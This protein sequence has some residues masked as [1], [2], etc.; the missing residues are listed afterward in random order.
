V[1]R[2]KNGTPSRHR[3]DCWLD[4][5]DTGRWACG[6]VA[7]TLS[8]TRQ[9]ADAAA[10][11][12]AKG[13]VERWNEQIAASRDM[14]WSPMIRAALHPGS[15]CSARAAGRAGRLIF[16]RSTDIPSP[17]SPLS[18]SGFGALGAQSRR[19][20]RGSSVCTLSRLRRRPRRPI[21]DL[22]AGPRQDSAAS[23]DVSASRSPIRRK[24][25]SWPIKTQYADQRAETINC[26]TPYPPRM[27]AA[28]LPAT[29]A[30]RKAAVMEY[31]MECPQSKERPSRA[32]WLA[33]KFPLS[34]AGSWR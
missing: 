19:R 18:C 30:R 29:T 8:S 21:C 1:R 31:S 2:V 28:K 10:R 11:A 4:S 33:V 9:V 13:V 25:H 15:T 32:R 22:D 23:L 27:T 7:S 26:A 16:E 6:H 24:S 3:L 12:E 34:T 14:L 17:R 20:C 5:A